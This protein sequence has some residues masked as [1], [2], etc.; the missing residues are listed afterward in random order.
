MTDR[1]KHPALSPRELSTL[2]LL[3][4]G[5]RPSEISSR[6]GIKEVTVHLHIRNA[7]TKLQAQ[8]REAAV[9]RAMSRG[10]FT[11]ED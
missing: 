2:K 10:L 11:I 3:A 5:K 8:T 6:L 4:E 1:T 7:R 9:A